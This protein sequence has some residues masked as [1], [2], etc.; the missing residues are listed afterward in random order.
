[1]NNVLEPIFEQLIGGEN[2]VMRSIIC[3]AHLILFECL[4]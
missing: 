2:Y 3:T 4:D 1:M